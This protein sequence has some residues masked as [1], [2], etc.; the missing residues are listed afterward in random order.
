MTLVTKNAILALLGKSSRNNVCKEVFQS[1]IFGVQFLLVKSGRTTLL[2]MWRVGNELAK[3]KTNFWVAAT[4]TSPHDSVHCIQCCNGYT[5]CPHCTASCPHCS[6]LSAPVVKSS[7]WL[8]PAFPHHHHHHWQC[9]HDTTTTTTNKKMSTWHTHD[10]LHNQ[11]HTS[12]TICSPPNN[13]NMT[14]TQSTSL[15]TSTGYKLELK[16]RIFESLF[17]AI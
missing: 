14:Q 8:L 16:S 17:K 11:H 5:Q 6:V 7:Y 9:Q 13:T 2:M 15:P 3:Y 10:H 1:V 12:S 4:F